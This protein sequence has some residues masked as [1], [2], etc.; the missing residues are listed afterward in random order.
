MR[1]SKVVFQVLNMGEQELDIESREKLGAPVLEDETGAV[2]KAKFTYGDSLYAKLQR[3]AGRLGVEQ[4]GI[5]RVPE[6]ERTDTNIKKIAT[7]VR[8]ALGIDLLG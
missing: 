4:R 8:E 5:E 3:F 7:M 2:Y 6:A 1:Y